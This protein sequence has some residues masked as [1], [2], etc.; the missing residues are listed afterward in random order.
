MHIFIFYYHASCV[1]SYGFRILF[2]VIIWWW[3]WCHCRRKLFKNNKDANRNANG[4]KAH[5]DRDRELKKS[6]QFFPGFFP[7]PPTLTH[8]M[9]RILFHFSLCGYTLPIYAFPYFLTPP[10]D[11]S[12]CASRSFGR[13]KNTYTHTHPL[14]K[15]SLGSF[16]SFQD[17]CLHTLF[18]RARTFLTSPTEMYSQ[19]GSNTVMEVY[20]D[21]WYFFLPFSL[22]VLITVFT[23]FRIFH[24]PHAH[25]MILAK[26]KN[27]SE[28]QKREVEKKHTE[29]KRIN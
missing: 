3:R 23:R 11:N 16:V 29:I 27:T 10:R 19:S 9:E 15:H 18:L 4:E 2:V 20:I 28:K 24:T 22:F 8:T 1:I 21:F 6:A 12:P 25:F 14:T 7:H 26:R 13:N 5:R 17:F